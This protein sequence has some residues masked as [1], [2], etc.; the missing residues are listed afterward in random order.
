MTDVLNKEKLTK[1]NGSGLDTDQAESEN[2]SN[3]E[4][5]Q[6]ANHESMEQDDS[7]NNGQSEE[8]TK[9]N[10]GH[11]NENEDNEIASMTESNVY[12]IETESEKQSDE[13]AVDAEATNQP[14]S[15]SKE[16]P[17]SLETEETTAESR[18]ET[19]TAAENYERTEEK[20]KTSYENSNQI[21]IENFWNNENQEIVTLA[22]IGL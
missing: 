18:V 1:G 9:E 20:P 19:S 16:Q 13:N 21:K 17:I 2:T 6:E 10:R 12:E 3:K 8:G 5:D 14:T 7:D 15:H 22:K 4:P 11:Q